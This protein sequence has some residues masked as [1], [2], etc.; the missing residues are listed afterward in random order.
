[1]GDRVRFSCF[2][3][4]SLTPLTITGVQLA[5]SW[6]NFVKLVKTKIFND[7]KVMIF[8]DVWLLPR[9]GRAVH[10]I[11]GG[12]PQVAHFCSP[13][14]EWSD[15][16]ETQISIQRSGWATNSSAGYFETKTIKMEMVRLSLRST[17]KNHGE[18][19]AIITDNN[20]ND[21]E[22]SN[23]CKP[24]VVMDGWVEEWLVVTLASIHHWLVY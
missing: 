20:D 3:K 10:R 18:E 14:S 15:I 17:C 13:F 5:P 16:T 12:R 8:L 1:M 9:E 24:I 2:F 19:V 7:L 6:F 23:E 11:T 22:N 21:N 4:L